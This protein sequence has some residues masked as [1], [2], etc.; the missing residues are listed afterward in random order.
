[1]KD[2]LDEHPQYA[3]EIVVHRSLINH[4]KGAAL[5]AGFALARGDVILVQGG[6]LEYSPSNYPELLAPFRDENVQIVFGSRFLNGFPKGMKLP[7]LVANL[8]LTYAT[9]L[10]YGARISDEATGYKVFRASVFLEKFSLSS[11]RFEFCP[12]FTSKALRVGFEINEVPIDYNPRGIL[13]GKKIRAWDGF[14][15]LWILVK[16]RFVRL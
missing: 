8:I 4:G 5:R 15:A 13:E 3:S 9:R 2:F 6:D 16:N 7:N 14:V 10:L 1:M 12:E 11:R